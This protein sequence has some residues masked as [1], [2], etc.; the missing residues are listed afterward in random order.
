AQDPRRCK[1]AA[2]TQ[3]RRSGAS[4]ATV[5]AR[6][7]AAGRTLRHAANDLAMVARLTRDFPRHL[8]RPLSARDVRTA[9]EQRLRTRELRFL[10]LVE[11]SIYG[12]PASPY[13]ALLR[14]A[15]CEL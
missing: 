11:C 1:Q 6:L 7:G 9:V 4:P 10:T 8:H 14:L 5:A 15:G 13:L 2:M 3:P 12:H